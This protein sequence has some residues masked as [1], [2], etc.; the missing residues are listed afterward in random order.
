MLRTLHLR[1]PSS[2][3]RSSATGDVAD[4]KGRNCT[5]RRSI[6]AKHQLRNTHVPATHTH[7]PTTLRPT[8]QTVSPFLS[9]PPIKTSPPP[10]PLLY[11]QDH[12]HRSPQAA[13]PSTQAPLSLLPLVSFQRG[14]SPSQPLWNDE[15]GAMEL[16]RPC[17]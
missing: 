6:Q 10:T 3:D 8:E 15:S 16:V 9:T 11:S 17:T 7:A 12:S 14:G 1:T 2:A 5:K 13:R 4:P